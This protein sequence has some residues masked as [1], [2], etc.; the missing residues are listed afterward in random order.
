MYEGIAAAKKEWIGLTAVVYIDDNGSIGD[1]IGMYEIKD[2]GQNEK[3]VS[4]NCIDIWMSVEKDCW[5]FGR[6]KVK[7]ILY[8]A[9]G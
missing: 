1:F 4:G 6:K 2:T 9:K 7:V 3:I 5:N 8:D